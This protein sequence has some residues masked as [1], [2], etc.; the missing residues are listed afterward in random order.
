MVE[1]LFTKDN[2][3]YFHWSIIIILLLLL[4]LCWFSPI[5][6]SDWIRSTET[7]SGK[8]HPLNIALSD[9]KMTQNNPEVQYTVNPIP[10]M[11][12][13]LGS[14]KWYPQTNPRR[15]DSIMDPMN[16]SKLYDDLIYNRGNMFTV[17]ILPVKSDPHSSIPR[18]P[19]SLPYD[20]DQI[21]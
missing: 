9:L 5:N 14:T 2:V 15:V 11:I 7:F 19:W 6:I 12:D 17:D 4:L 3:Y 1:I 8:D 10:D 21:S 20:P 16:E 18:Y 13:K